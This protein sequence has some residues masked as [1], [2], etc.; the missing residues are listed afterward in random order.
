MK[1]QMSHQC[2]WNRCALRIH[3]CTIYTSYLHCL[4]HLVRLA[5]SHIRG[6]LYFIW[7]LTWH[8]SLSSLVHAHASHFNRLSTHSHSL[9][10]S[11]TL[12]P[13]SIE[14]Y[15][16]YAMKC[17]KLCQKL[18]LLIHFRKFS[19]LI[20]MSGNGIGMIVDLVHHCDSLNCNWILVFS[21]IS[22]SLTVVQSEKDGFIFHNNDAL[23]SEA[24]LR[25]FLWNARPFTSKFTS[26]W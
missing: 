7:V 18:F 4:K 9:Y 8:P 6:Y 5:T 23:K 17:G 3:F 15:P 2:H 22:P 1:K 20:A 12:F 13:N 24:F 25:L 19:M 21:H 10:S 26:R 11:R 16:F 14:I